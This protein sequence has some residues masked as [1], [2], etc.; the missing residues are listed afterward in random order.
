MLNFVGP[1]DLGKMKLK[2]G[3]KDATREL[4]SPPKPSNIL[5]APARAPSVYKGSN[6]WPNKAEKPGFVHRGL[7]AVDLQI[8]K[9]KNVFGSSLC[10]H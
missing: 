2:K 7:K 6:K 5:D 8:A 3:N 10:R 4:R 9:V 1:G